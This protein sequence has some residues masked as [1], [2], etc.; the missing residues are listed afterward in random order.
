MGVPET[1]DKVYFILNSDF[2]PIY[3]SKPVPKPFKKALGEIPTLGNYNVVAGEDFWKNFPS[4]PLPRSV[5][6]GWMKR[7]KRTG[8]RC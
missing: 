8:N 3:P 1:W 5:T 6:K 4:K 7:L 2:M